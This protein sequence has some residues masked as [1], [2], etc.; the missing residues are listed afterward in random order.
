MFVLWFITRASNNSIDIIHLSTSN[1][2]CRYSRC[3]RWCVNNNKMIVQ[4]KE[5][6][7]MKMHILNLFFFF[8]VISI[9]HSELA[10][11]LLLCMWTCFPFSEMYNMS[12]SFS[13]KFALKIFSHTRKHRE[14]KILCFV[15]KSFIYIELLRGK[16]VK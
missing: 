14:N 10:S 7:E 15:R 1:T 13:R 11:I 2:K 6:I 3:S 9:C 12:R 5:K 4:P 8:Y 16:I